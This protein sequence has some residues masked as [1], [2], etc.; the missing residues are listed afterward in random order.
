[1]RISIIGAGYVGLVSGV[2]LSE[3]GHQVVCVDQIREKVES[4]LKG[5][6]PIYEPGLDELLRRNLKARRFT[7]NLDLARAVEETEVTMIA[8]PTPCR[9]GAIDLR[10]V[11]AAA[12]QI[13]HVLRKKDGYHVV[14]VKSTVIPSTSDTIVRSIL[15]QTSRKALGE[16]G[17]CTNPEFLREGDAI[18]DFLRP[19][20]IVI[21]SDDERSFR[22]FKRVYS[23][24]HCP[25]VHTNL[26]TAELIKYTSNSL[27]ASLIS[28][29]NEIASIA[30]AVG[31]ID[32][33][34]VMRGLHLDNRL[35]PF[36]KGSGRHLGER[37]TPGIL[38]Y[39]RAGCGYGGSC[40][41]KDVPALCA[42]AE[43]HGYKARLL[44]DVISINRRQPLRLM[45]RLDRQLGGLRNKKVAVWGIAF[46]PGTDDVRDTPAK[47]IVDF[48]VKAGAKVSVYDPIGLEHAR[49]TLFKDCPL[50]Y[51]ET[52]FK[53]VERAHA[54]VV[55][56]SWPQFKNVD[57]RTLS[58]LMKKKAFVVDGR[59]IY[60]R[61]SVLQ[62]GLRYIGVGYRESGEAA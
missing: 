40:L 6:S 50:A 14:A 27:L 61:Q 19:D 24:F 13:G 4:I 28:Y 16:F 62:A 7:A 32:V 59:R 45:E 51:P 58:N 56:T 3:V 34:D 30:E 21:G 1:M 42:V 47:P 25:I 44:R 22:V 23:P 18:K 54:L 43:K 38:A 60:E 53:A 10:F 36:V 20:R 17:L 9:N 12:R 37:L 31:N 15:Q 35:T 33:L 2:C 57:F 41:P 29:S 49:K 5:K 8:V 26:R 52:Q 39:L 46:K 11:K 55:V 48:L